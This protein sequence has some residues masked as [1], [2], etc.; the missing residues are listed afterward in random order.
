MP[1]SVIQHPQPGHLLT[2]RAKDLPRLRV[3]HT[4]ITKCRD[5]LRPLRWGPATLIIPF[6]IHTSPSILFL[7]HKTPVIPRMLARRHH[8]RATRNILPLIWHQNLLHP[9][10]LMRL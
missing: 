2:S 4:Y 7:N 8:S 1:P 5:I 9:P 3:R 10:H 6:R